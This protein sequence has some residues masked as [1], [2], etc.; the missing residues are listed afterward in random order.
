M[1]PA[2]GSEYRLPDPAVGL[3]PLQQILLWE[4]RG[5]PGGCSKNPPSIP[6]AEVPE[7]SPGAA[8]PPLHSFPLVQPGRLLLQQH[9]PM[10]DGKRGLYR[11][12]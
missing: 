2:G 10:R 6:M 9:V 5:N 12:T 1:P 8:P 11:V 4:G 3:E 7:N